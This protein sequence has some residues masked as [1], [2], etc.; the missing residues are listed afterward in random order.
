MKPAFAL[1]LS[2]DG[3]GLLR[4]TSRG[5]LSVGEVSLDDPDLGQSLSYLR[6][7]ALA[8][9]PAGLAT[10][11]II[12]NSQILYTDIEAPGPSEAERRAQIARALEG[13][14]PY[15]VAD[16]V[17]DWQGD[18]PVV[19]VAVVARET[20]AEA[21][22][23]AEDH[24]FGPLG[25]VAIPEA[26][27]FGAEP[28]FGMASR[29]ATHLPQG[30]VLER[31]PAPVRIIQLAEGAPQRP[32]SEADAGAAP[33][34]VAAPE[35]AFAEGAET[36]APADEPEPAE[37]GA[38]PGGKAIALD[39]PRAE[40]PPEEAPPE[41]APPE[42][43]RQPAEPPPAAAAGPEP[44][45]EAAAPSEAPAP[46]A[47]PPPPEQPPEPVPEPAPE[48]PP[49]Q[50]APPPRA[51]GKGDSGR[52][53]KA[54]RKPPKSPARKA[55]A[56]V[57]E[58]RPAPPPPEVAGF[59]GIGAR[60][61]ERRADLSGR[62]MLLPLA[63]A[64]VVVVLLVVLWLVMGL[65]TG[66][67][68]TPEASA[69]AP[70]P[71]ETAIAAPEPLRPPGALQDTPLAAPAADAPPAD[72]GTDNPQTADPATDPA[73]PEAADAPPQ[74]G[75]QPP[76]QP[77]A[78]PETEG[79]LA[80]TGADAAP[81]PPQ[82]AAANA[83][84]ADSVPGPQP[85]PAPAATRAA[86]AFPQIDPALRYELTGVWTLAPAETGLPQPDR[87]DAGVASLPD[88][89]VAVPVA[90]PALSAFGP[91]TAGRAPAPL[92]DPPPFRAPPRRDAL[93]R[94]VPTP[95]GV[96]TAEGVTLFAGRPPIVA[97]PRPAPA[98]GAE[99]APETLAAPAASPPVPDETLPD[100]LPAP[101]PDPL[102][103]FRPRP[104][105]GDLAA[106]EDAAAPEAPP[107]PPL[108]GTDL[109]AAAPDAAPDE[110][111]GE[112]AARG[113][114]TFAALPDLA[115]A[116]PRPVPAALRPGAAPA[117]P[118]PA[119]D[120]DAAAGPSTFA[121]LPDLAPARPRPP[122]AAVL[123]R[124]QAAAERE[125]ALAEASDLAVASSLRPAPRPRDFSAGIAAALALAVS[126]PEPEPAGA[127]P[128]PAPE[129]DETLPEDDGE[130]DV[131]AGVPDIP[132]S[133]TVAE[134]A[135]VANAIRL[136]E[137][138]L[139]GVYGASGARRAL[140]RMP[141]GRFLRVE[142]GDRLDGG[143]VAAISES[144]LRYVKN[145]RTIVLKL[146]QEG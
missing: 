18:G 56:V 116:R 57:A 11:L 138:N 43:D 142:V 60:I 62:G 141:T 25:F 92:P 90:A 135:T 74:V 132:T 3:I 41:Q 64:G 44:V 17:F 54:G 127:A 123:A 87:P 58:R 133:A 107:P 71:L 125:R 48:P 89:Q 99:A 136:N 47:P 50:P 30:E 20:L 13:R 59:T 139:I 108:P 80:G 129:P 34:P 124:A 128:T 24:R 131:R 109:A 35:P 140:V 10:K 61:A 111:P 40:A 8:L 100:A 42:D 145:G 37:Q 9:S 4:R 39:A 76:A 106:E 98:I 31:D 77:I 122:P 113:L 103:A 110:A 112:D 6:K 49:A 36:G 101:A 93:G 46:V 23:F 143:Q 82:P 146:L 104:R 117:V 63:A 120:P 84:E 97:P 14:T 70:P 68:G 55:P 53:S 78:T 5:W 91:E 21:E 118:P 105:P 121:A 12:P 16:L 38:D 73:A 22:S 29:A 81:R 115:T 126:Q 88:R 28:F 72:A 95:E 85:D 45:Q 75:F 114:Q 94:I 137:V 52:D 2:H 96:I 134:Q 15:D 27:Q 65:L 33:A 130:P 7:T 51:R 66:Q 19:Q 1:N 102:E 26:G 144:E 83:P 32:E 67:R 69:P 86:E 79:S 119:P